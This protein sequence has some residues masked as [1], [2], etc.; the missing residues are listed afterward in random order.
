MLANVSSSKV[1][2]TNGFVGYMSRPDGM[3]ATN[4]SDGGIS[5]VFIC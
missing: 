1:G 3:F 4:A 5:W 2:G